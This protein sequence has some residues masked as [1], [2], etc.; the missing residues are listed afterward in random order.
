MWEPEVNIA[1]G[2]AGVVAAVSKITFIDGE[3]GKLLYRG[4]EVPVLARESSFEE[5]CYL[6]LYG[7]LPTA[8]QL[9]AFNQLLLDNR[10]I[11]PGLLELIRSLP[12]SAKPMD[13]LRTAVSVMAATD[14]SPSD[15][16]RVANLRR[17]ARFIAQMPSIVAAHWRMHQGEAPI[18]PDHSLGH[19]AN[20]VYM[21]FGRAP[22]PIEAR[23][24]DI[25]MI[26]M[27]D[28]GLNASTFA[29]RVTASTLAD[30]YAAFVTAVGT[31]NGPLHGA[32]NSEAMKMLLEIE[33]EEKVEG[34]IRSQLL[35]GKR[36]MGFGHRVYKT[37]DPRAILLREILPTLEGDLPTPRWCEMAVAVEDQAHKQKNLYPNV[38]FY[39]APTLYSLGFPMEMF[40]PIFACSRSVGW[41]AHIME[42]YDDNKL[43]RPDAVYNGPAPR[44]YIAIKERNGNHA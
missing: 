38:D 22:R 5:V 1:R 29:A 20:F 21:L 25:A 10:R 17:A 44:S 16:S 8:R 14:S 42:Q 40:T 18:D 39:C 11:S 30:M 41:A 31:L 27:A 19:A 28:H 43:I 37:G 4:Y 12:G 3:N 34:Y 36:I 7:E 33:S 32:A 23:F 2:L 9:T 26:L 13:V 35:A 24:L 6:I 15:V